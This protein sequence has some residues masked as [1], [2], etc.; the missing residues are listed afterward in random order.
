MSSTRT[1]TIWRVALLVFFLSWS[2]WFGG[3]HC[4]AMIGNTLL[5]TGTLEFRELLPPDAEREIFRMLSVAGILV[6]PAYLVALLSGT[7]VLST[8][9]L[10]FRE[11]GWLMMAAI[12]FYLA[13][14]VELYVG[15]ID[16]RMVY[17][18]FFTTADN[19]VFRE[20]FQERLH[21]LGGAPIVAMVL[22]YVTAGLVV[23]QPMRRSVVTQ[24]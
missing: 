23:F 9:P 7:V 21:A 18:E 16:A 8:I 6:V 2:L 4:R 22:H 5:Q 12:L 3:V 20:L 15:S 10:R 14:P 24:A 11:H 17:E 13:A 19:A 1:F